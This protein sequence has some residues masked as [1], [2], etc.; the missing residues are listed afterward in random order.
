MTKQFGESKLTQSMANA[1]LVEYSR[2]IDRR[3]RIQNL[4]FLFETTKN[5][6]VT[7][8]GDDLTFELK[9]AR[10]EEKYRLVFL[11]TYYVVVF[12]PTND[13]TPIEDYVIDRS[14][15]EATVNTRAHSVLGVLL[16][17]EG[18]AWY[19][20]DSHE[21]GLVIESLVWKI[22]KAKTQEA[23]KRPTA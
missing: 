9:R 15:I 11:P 8:V 3:E 22:K 20:S 7:I 13:K 16:P 6:P 21:Y 17:V 12:L 23:A 1:E 18:K 5:K 19:K 4:R 14:N 10:T 2:G